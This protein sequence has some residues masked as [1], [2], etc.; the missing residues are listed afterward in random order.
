M[1]MVRELDCIFLGPSIREGA[2]VPTRTLARTTNPSGRPG[3]SR[4]DGVTN[5]VRVG[6]DSLVSRLNNGHRIHIGDFDM[7]KAT[8]PTT[9]DD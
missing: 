3:S 4:K 6:A 5:D 8:A 7:R 9:P 1:W 2:G